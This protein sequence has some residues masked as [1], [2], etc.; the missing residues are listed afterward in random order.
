[1]M[2]PLCPNCTD[3]MIMNQ[4]NEEP[5]Q[6]DEGYDMVYTYTCPRCGYTE[7]SINVKYPYQKFIPN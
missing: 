7:D 6:T 5:I 2:L 3:G 4:V 1:M